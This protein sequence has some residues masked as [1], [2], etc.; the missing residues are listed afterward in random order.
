MPIALNNL[1]QEAGIRDP[2]RTIS[3]KVRRGRKSNRQ[4]SDLIIDTELAN[5][6][7]LEDKEH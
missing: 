4:Q 5:K 6:S 1:K 3:I 7:G 2:S